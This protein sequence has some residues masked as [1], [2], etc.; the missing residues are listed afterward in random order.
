MMNNLRHKLNAFRPVDIL[1]IGFLT[2]LSVVILIRHQKVDALQSYLVKHLVMIGLYL[3]ILWLFTKD[4]NRLTS[5]LRHWFPVVLFPFIYRGFEP[6]IHII[7]PHE[8]D[9]V[10]INI[11]NAIFGCQPCLWFEGIINPW[12]TELLQI[13]YTTYYYFPTLL[14]VLLYAKARDEAYHNF[15][16]AVSLTLYGSFVGFLLVPVLGPRFFMA[17]LFTVPL[18]GKLFA[19][20]IAQFMDVSGLRGGAFPSAHS[21]IALITLIFA[22]RYVRT[23]FYFALPIMIALLISTIYGRYHYVGDVLAGLILGALSNYFAPKINA[24]WCKR[25]SA[26]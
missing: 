9:Q 24:W 7:V 12:L 14:G 23:F 17:E 5:I 11:D 20:L 26:A 8:L 21:A 18:K 13:S 25:R 4:N 1:A 19:P 15:L 16:L 22:H 3:L 2:I 6:L 10:F